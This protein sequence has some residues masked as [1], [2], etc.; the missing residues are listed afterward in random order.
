MDII[1]SAD[2]C[3]GCSACYNI[4]PKQAIT[5]KED[6]YGYLLPNINKKQCIDCGACKRVCPAINKT[7]FS[8]PKNVYAAIAKNSI[9]YKTTTSGGVATIF[10]KIVIESNGV[11]YGAAFQDGRVNHIRVDNFCDVEKLKG[12]KYVQSSINNI[13]RNVKD[14]LHSDKLVLF[15]GTS[16]QVDGLLKYLQD[17]YQNLITVNLIC[18]GVPA[19]K[20]LKEHIEHVTED[21][22][23]N[24]SNITFRDESG[25]NLKIKREQQI[26]YCKKNFYD[27]YYLGFLKSLFYRR[28]C[29]SCKYAQENR[30]GDITIGDFWGFDESKT[31]FVVKHNDGLSVVMVNSDKG[32]KFFEKA[33]KRLYFQERSLQEAV[34][35]NKQLR[36]PSEKHR[37]YDKF[38]RLYKKYGFEI[39][40]QKCLKVDMLIYR[41]WDMI[42]HKA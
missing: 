25:F 19:Y 26:L 10:S 3:Y 28:C 42:H 17:D 21:I 18:H 1:C 11:V 33:K 29:Y 32:K 14:D 39:A 23:I 34:R 8:T 37:N 38:K 40:A 2:D 30:I 15:I 13:Y 9:D 24:N 5:M 22:E 12:S 6:I 4:C 7:V 36:N 31:S 16:C 35:G 20:L 41:I 27:T